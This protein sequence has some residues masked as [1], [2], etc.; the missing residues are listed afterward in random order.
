MTLFVYRI[1]I[2]LL[3]LS[4]LFVAVY[5]YIYIKLVTQTSSRGFKNCD[6]IE[7]SYCNFNTV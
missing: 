3:D 7:V 2:Y 5:I 4:I 6:G 1:E